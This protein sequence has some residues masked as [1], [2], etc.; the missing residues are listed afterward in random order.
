M[1]D[2]SNFNAE[3]FSETNFTEEN[4][5][6]NTYVTYIPYGF[7]PEEYEESRKI[8]KAATVS[9]AA[10]LVMS[11]I[12][13]I[14]NIALVFI[15]NA[16]GFISEDVFSLLNDPAISQ[17]EQILFSLI[18]FVLTFSAVF[19]IA[20]I[21]IS[22]LISF[23]KP[24]KGT[25]LPFFFFGIGF[26]AFANIAASYAGSIFESFGVEYEVNFGENPDGFFGFMLTLI[27]TVIV[28]ALAE[29]FAC[30]GIILGNLKCFGE[31]FAVITSSILFGLMHGN[32]EQMPFAFLVG[33]VLGYVTVKSESLWPA[34]LIHAFNNF[35]SVAFDYFA[36]DTSVFIQN[37]VYII[38]LCVSMLL[39]MISLLLLKNK[40]SDMFKFKKEEKI[41]EKKKYKWFFGNALIIIFIVI[42]ML[43]A[44]SFF[45]L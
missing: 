14:L 43:E 1:T 6:T 11:G 19:K 10:F 20:Q 24:K 26:C 15:L 34:I 5:T 3:S 12:I 39:G 7:T 33:L 32:F 13:V 18:A 36:G 30:R 23:K 4:K 40:D 8:K 38:F 25:A 35:I 28:P 45:I 27:S 17:V 29:E 44:F 31:G 41:A 42:S 22:D 16:T 9:G 37:T 2:N 21:R